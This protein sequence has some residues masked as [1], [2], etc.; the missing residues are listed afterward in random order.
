[1]IWWLMMPIVFLVVIAHGYLARWIAGSFVSEE[2]KDVA[3]FSFVLGMAY[4][5]S[6]S[7]R[8]LEGIRLLYPS[9]GYAFGVC[10]IWYL[11][12]KREKATD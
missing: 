8:E 6:G 12:F 1:M 2:K 10:A 5:A 9:L 7:F 11:F 4:V 3:G